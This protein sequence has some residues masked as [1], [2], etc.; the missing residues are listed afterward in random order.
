MTG[1]LYNL[2]LLVKLMVLL[3]QILFNL[4]IAEVNLM[5]ISAQHVPSLHRV[6]SRYLKVFTSSNLWPFMLIPALM[7]SV[8]LVVIL[9]FHVLTFHTPLLSL[10]TSLLVRS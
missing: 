8:L 3:H 7:L 6:E 2:N 10:S 1:D 5:W 9:L 4:A